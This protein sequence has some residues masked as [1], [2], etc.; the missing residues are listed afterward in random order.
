MA[1]ADMATGWRYAFLKAI[2]RL[3]EERLMKKTRKFNGKVYKLIGDYH[4][5]G[6]DWSGRGHAE[7]R[8]KSLKEEGYLVRIVPHG[9]Y[10]AV[11]A[12]K[13]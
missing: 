5:S 11:Y 9:K 12:R 6:Y 8:A 13:K 2:P 1:G 7:R 4:D 10:K 3:C